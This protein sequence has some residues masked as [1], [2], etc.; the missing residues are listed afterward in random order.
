M[1]LAAGRGSRLAPL[2]D[3]TPKPLLSIHGQ[4]LIAH[5]LTWLRRAGIQRVIINLFHLADEI[6]RELGDGSRFGV[7]IAYSSEPELLETGGAIAHARSLLGEEPFVLLNGDIWTDFDFNHL[8]TA[9]G[10]HVQAHL[11]AT[12]TPAHRSSGDFA[13]QH[14]R[15]LRPADES[16]RAYVYCGIAII[17]AG[18]VGARR[19]K[20]SLRE[21]FFA[22][23]ARG[24]LS[25]Q[26]FNGIWRDIG[27][28][29][30][31]MS[32]RN[33]PPLPSATAAE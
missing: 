24:E 12:P 6:R 13:L 25:G 27:T 14:H 5:Q 16:R 33:G 7:D 2:T 1:I 31:L 28:P 10:R 30:Q 9:L 23:A 4:P 22:A 21:A 19:G 15:L 8:P 29:D 32:V 18:I 17:R 20:F 3:S 26:Y 11:V